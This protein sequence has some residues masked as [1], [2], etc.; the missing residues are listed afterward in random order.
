MGVEDE[1][2]EE[3]EVVEIEDE[4]FEDVE[5]IEEPKN[6]SLADHDHDGVADDVDTCPNTPTGLNVDEQGCRASGVLSVNYTA[7]KKAPM[8]VSGT[9]YDFYNQYYNELRQIA[10]HLKYNPH[11]NLTLVTPL[12]A[13]GATYKARLVDGQ[14]RVVG[15]A[16]YL[17]RKFGVSA[18]RIN[19]QVIL[20]PFVVKNDNGIPFTSGRV[21]AKLSSTPFPS[22]Y[23]GNLKF[24][25]SLILQNSNS[26][27]LE[28][29]DDDGDGHQNEPSETFLT[30][31]CSAVAK[32]KLLLQYPKG[33]WCAPAPVSR[34]GPM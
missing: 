8:D 21:F 3:N 30:I 26:L 7:T 25:N 13:N 15:L 14:R 33:G 9:L 1:E 18:S 12:G 34:C 16:N 32:F 11:R 27:A 24:D 22:E 20:N 2:V 28:G 4:V 17:V 31:L 23:A 10:L 19:T 6:I 29:N 5:E